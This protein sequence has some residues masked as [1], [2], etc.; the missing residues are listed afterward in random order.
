MH[1]R[2]A[3]IG[4]SGAITEKLHTVKT[5]AAAHVPFPLNLAAF[6]IDKIRN[7]VKYIG[8]RG[9]ILVYWHFSPN[10]APAAPV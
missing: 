4:S 2:S 6:K 1:G 7:P 5:E 9:K 8:G 10:G 3:Q